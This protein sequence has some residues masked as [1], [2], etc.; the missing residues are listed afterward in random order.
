MHHAVQNVKLLQQLPTPVLV[1]RA[2][3]AARQFPPKTL[4]R[5][6]RVKLTPWSPALRC[7]GRGGWLH[8]ITVYK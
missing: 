8:L 6:A 7:V 5:A 4:T 2:L 1:Q 3:H